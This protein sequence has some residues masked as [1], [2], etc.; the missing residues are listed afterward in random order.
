MGYGGEKYDWV[1]LPIEC[2]STANS[3]LPVGDNMWTI[4]GLTENKVV[5]VG[6]TYGFRDHNGLFYYACDN[7]VNETDKHN[8]SARLMYIPTKNEIYNANI[9]AWRNHMGG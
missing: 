2:A 6:G 1:M 3:L 9:A 8:Y 4:S 5:A 7:N